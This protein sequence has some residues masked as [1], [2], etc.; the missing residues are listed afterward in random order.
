MRKQAASLL[1][2]RAIKSA[3]F[4]KIQVGLSL[5]PLNLETDINHFNAVLQSS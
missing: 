1:D 4:W 5:E 2:I 3:G